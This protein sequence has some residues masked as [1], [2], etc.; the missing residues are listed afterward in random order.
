MRI[1]LQFLKADYSKSTF[2]AQNF[3]LFNENLTFLRA[4]LGIVIQHY[5]ALNIY[6][7]F[8]EEHT[9]M[10]TTIETKLIIGRIYWSV[11]SY[12]RDPLLSPKANI[13]SPPPS[14]QP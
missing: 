14:S 13:I 11:L 8:E 3:R 5:L 4:C 2:A 9:D 6:V 10:E 12:C 1:L 7:C